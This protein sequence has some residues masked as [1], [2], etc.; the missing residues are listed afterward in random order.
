MQLRCILDIK[1]QIWLLLQMKSF[2]SKK[3]GRAYPCIFKKQI[4]HPWRTRLKEL[5]CKR[6]MFITWK[7]F[8]SLGFIRLKPSMEDHF[9]KAKFWL[10][11]SILQLETGK[12][13]ENI[14]T[15]D[16]STGWKNVRSNSAKCIYIVRALF[17]TEMMGEIT[18][19]VT[20]KDGITTHWRFV[21]QILLCRLLV[22]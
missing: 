16:C 5:L 22:L 14:K 10:L 19:A 13:F 2:C 21:C 3:K 6:S 4:V 11:K 1:E 12:Y 7:P 18:L 17:V 8:A 20:Y 15:D 9:I